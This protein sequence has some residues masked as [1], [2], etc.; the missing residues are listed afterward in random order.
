MYFTEPR[1][2]ALVAIACSESTIPEGQKVGLGLRHSKTPKPVEPRST[3][4]VCHERVRYRM[5]RS[6]RTALALSK[7][8]RGHLLFLQCLNSIHD[9]INEDL[10]D[11][12][13][14]DGDARERLFVTYP[15]PE[16]WHSSHAGYVRSGN[17]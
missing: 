2:C 7:D 10:L 13:L 15:C 11:L 17:V 16:S 4:I 1:L 6:T 9:Q 5:E 8:Q 14:V 3:S 12:D